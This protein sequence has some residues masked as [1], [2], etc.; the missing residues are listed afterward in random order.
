MLTTD[1]IVTH[2]QLLHGPIR[3]SCHSHY[4]PRKTCTRLGPWDCRSPS[5]WHAATTGRQRHPEVRRRLS[6]AG[7]EPIPEDDLLPGFISW[8]HAN[9]VTGVNHPGAR[10]ALYQAET[11]AP[12]STHADRG[13]A[14]IEVSVQSTLITKLRTPLHFS[15]PTYS[16]KRSEDGHGYGGQTSDQPGGWNRCSVFWS[17][18]YQYTHVPKMIS[19]PTRPT[20]P[21]RL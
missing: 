20:V 2:L 15:T 5:A 12:S 7:A 17:Y 11:E 6:T 10:L 8:L 14:F 16:C 18:M 1:S 3:R 21:F 19:L 9:G 13:V 4:H